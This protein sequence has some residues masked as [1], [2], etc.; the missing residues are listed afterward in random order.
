[1]SSP[2]AT[3]KT[4]RSLRQKA[5]KQALKVKAQQ[6]AIKRAT[7]IQQHESLTSRIAQWKDEIL[8]KWKLDPSTSSRSYD[9]YILSIYETC[10]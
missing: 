2:I 3:S 1:M 8:P 6:D 10:S 4:P 7:S 5:E 9:E